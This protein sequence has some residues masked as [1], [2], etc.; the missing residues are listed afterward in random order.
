MSSDY[1]A[2]GNNINVILTNQNQAI[3]VYTKNV[4]NTLLFSPEFIRAF[5]L[6]LG[7]MIAIPLTGDKQLAKGLFDESTQLIRDAAASNQ[8]EGLTVNESIPD[9]MRVRGYASDWAYPAGSLTY[10]GPDAMGSV[11]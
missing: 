1:D 7:H 5:A 10:Y 2:N 8:N 4:T 11:S 6:Y 3:A 9:W